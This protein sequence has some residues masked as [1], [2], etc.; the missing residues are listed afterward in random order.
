M[1]EQDPKV[2]AHNFDEVTLGYTEEMAIEEAKNH[3]TISGTVYDR[4][5]T[6][7]AWSEG[8]QMK[9]NYIDNRGYSS[10]LSQASG[11][12]E[13]VWEDILFTHGKKCKKS[14]KKV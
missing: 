13:A 11:G 5:G 3:R 8:L 10:I 7:L 6:K 4:N 1:P 12:V 2:R 14:H 9:R